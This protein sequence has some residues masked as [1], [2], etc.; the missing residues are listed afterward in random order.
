MRDLKAVLE[1]KLD[2]IVVPQG[3]L[4]DANVRELKAAFLNHPMFANASQMPNWT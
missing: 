2:R 3:N 1:G 4:L